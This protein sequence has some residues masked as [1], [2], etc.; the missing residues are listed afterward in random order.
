MTTNGETNGATSNDNTASDAHLT[1]VDDNLRER[2]SM[3]RSDQASRARVN[4]FR[5]VDLPDD[6]DA[7]WKSDEDGG[8][9]IFLNKRKPHE[10]RTRAVAQ[11]MQMLR[12]GHIPAAIGM[13]LAGI[14]KA[15]HAMKAA[16]AAAAG[17]A[18][19]SAAVAVAVGATALGIVPPPAVV[20][21]VL[22]ESHH[23]ERPAA[24]A[25]GGD[26]VSRSRPGSGAP[27][28]HGHIAD[29]PRGPAAPA[30]SVPVGTYIGQWQPAGET[31]PAGKDA[32]APAAE[33]AADSTAS[34][35]DGIPAAP[36][37]DPTVEGPT[38]SPPE[39]AA[40]QAETPPVEAPSADLPTGELPVDAPP[41]D[42]TG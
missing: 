17:A 29:P 23:A 10:K 18:T 3:S 37:S 21:D 11:I 16:P 13:A 22:G 38:V 35:S 40:P 8:V 15:A 7:G 30:P 32:P 31:A 39:G 34:V 4:G 36:L 20:K 26:P 1:A 41:A 33:P 5:H 9:T 14:H 42:M 28:Q 12:H 24:A 6:M 25:P 2:Q 27:P 19:G